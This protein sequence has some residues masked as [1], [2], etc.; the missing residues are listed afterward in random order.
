MHYQSVHVSYRMGESSTSLQMRTMKEIGPRK[1]TMYTVPR[2]ISS[3]RQCLVTKLGICLGD[4]RGVKT[5]EDCSERGRSD[6]VS[7]QSSER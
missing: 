1:S 7:C 3:S 4:S 6:D 5:D 2:S